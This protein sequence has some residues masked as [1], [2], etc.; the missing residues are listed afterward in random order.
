[1][2]TSYFLSLPLLV[3]GT[4]AIA[5][6]SP[7]TN[8]NVAEDSHG[9]PIH[10]PGV[11][12]SDQVISSIVDNMAFSSPIGNM[13]SMARPQ[14]KLADFGRR[15]P[16]RRDGQIDAKF[17]HGVASGDLLKDSIILW[18]KVT[19]NS[20]DIAVTYQVSPTEDF[21]Q[22]TTSATL[23]TNDQV[24]YTVKVE[25]KNL[26]PA[27]TYYYRFLAIPHLES[28]NKNMTLTFV[29]SPVGRTHTLPK[30]DADISQYK[31]A[32]V[33]CA[34]YPEGF[35]NAY[36]GIARRK[37]VDLVLHLGDYI[38]EY[39]NGEYGD[40]TAIGRIPDPNY[41]IVTL[42]D[43]RRRHAQY[44]TD[45][46]LQAVHLVHPF[47]TVWDDH[48]FADNAYETGAGNHQPTEGPWDVRKQAAI[49]AYFEYMPIR[50]AAIDSFGRIFRGVQ[51]GKLMDLV[52]LDTRIWGRDKT[53]ERKGSTINDPN[54]S[55]LGQDQEAWLY[56]TL[57][58]SSSRG[59]QW[60]ILGQQVVM[61]PVKIA[62]I[63][64]F[65]D[66]WDGYPVVRQ[67]L[68]DYLVNKKIK[69]TV[70][71]TGDI[72]TA[73]AFDVPQKSP[74]L[75]WQYNP[76]SGSG[77]VL[78]EFVGT[79]VTSPGAGKLGAAGLW[80]SQPHLK[81]SNGADRGYMIV[82][83]S[84]QKV[85]TEFVKMATI[86]ERSVAESIDAVVETQKGAGFLKKK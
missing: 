53:D 76:W 58:Q 64:L 71:L 67:R 39:G 66:A 43:Y 1:M 82:T 23:L 46:D 55:L 78:T 54:R 63:P 57:S 16:V 75:L 4:F 73:L 5:Q 74:Y 8:G 65:A 40:G 52:M 14:P 68:L 9:H 15:K 18:T 11:L 31:L 28:S 30:E 62:G 12:P 44:K 32:V 48:E 17:V 77:S 22:I 13:P 56:S 50:P 37:D 42:S 29:V 3:L 19:T 61:A 45:P 27:T 36:A 79:S 26:L 81:Y 85:S 41:E 35:F 33:S 6:T 21:S 72:H 60:R 38:Y 7:T 51:I 86:K 49:R 10:T 34:N 20:P 70:V 80:V 47:M 25:A 83:V 69:D 84:K 24:D 2:K 59:A